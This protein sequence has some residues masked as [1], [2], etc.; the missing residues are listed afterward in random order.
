MSDEE[1]RRL[2]GEPWERVSLA[3]EIERLSRAATNRDGDYDFERRLRN[4]AT[5]I[6]AVLRAAETVLGDHAV[7]DD[8][9]NERVLRRAL[10]DCDGA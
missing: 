9:W 7:I 6:V 3:D 8:S 2:A 1:V 4:A 10:E 5:R